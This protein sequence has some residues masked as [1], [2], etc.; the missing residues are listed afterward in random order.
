M[1][2]SFRCSLLSVV[3]PVFL[4]GPA[5]VGCPVGDIDKNCRIDLA[6]IQEF[7]QKWL[8]EGVCTDSDCANLDGVGVVNM[9]DFA[10]LAE[11][12]SEDQSQLVI[13]EFMAVNNEAYADEQGKF[14]DWIEIYNPMDTTVDLE[15]WYLTDDADE[16]PNLTKWQF[17][18]GVLL[19]PGEFIVVFASGENRRDP[20][21]PLHTNFQLGDED[22]D[23]ALVTPDGKTIAHSYLAYPRQIGDVSYGLMQFS[24]TL[25]AGGANVSYHVPTSD[26]AG[27]DFTPVDFPDSSWPTGP[28]GLNF[29]FGGT[30][31]FS[32][33][34]CVYEEGQHLGSNV[35]TYGI[36]GGFGGAT[37]GPLLD[38]ATGD[39][40]GAA[41]ALGQSGGVTWQAS[42]TGGSD[43]AAGTDAYNTFG[44]FADMTGVIYYGSVGW[45]VDIT[46]TN[47]EPGTEYTFAASAARNEYPDRWTRYT[48]SGADTHTNASTTGVYE[49]PGSGGA[50][51][52]FNTGDNHNEGY[53][54]RWTGIRA[55]D[56]TFKVRAEADPDNPCS[57]PRKAYAFDVF[58]LK[59]GFSGTNLSGQM[60]GVN[61]SVWTRAEFYLEAGERDIF[62][63]LTLRMKYEDG[64]V[65]YLNGEKV[66]SRNDPAILAWNSSATANR[67]IEE[68]AE[69]E[70]INLT[71]YVGLLRDGKNVLAIHGLNDS[72]DDGEFLVLP[73]LVAAS[74]VGV[75]QYFT[76]P[77]PRTF[78][79]EGAQGL[80]SEVWF[81]HDRGFYDSSFDLTLSTEMSS[82]E[83]RY[84]TDGS[85]PT[86]SHGR[87][88]SGPV[89]INGTSTIRAVAVKPGYLDSDVKTHTYIFVSDVIHQ[90]PNGERP[91]SNW[92]TD[93]T[94]GQKFEYGMDTA[95]VNHGT[96]GPLLDDALTAIPTMSVVTD[97]DNLFYDSSSSSTGGIYVNAG[98]DGRAWERPT[99]LE[100]IYPPDPQG[101]GFPDLLRAADG[102]AGSQWQLPRNMQ[103]GFQIDCGIRIRGGY[104]RSGGNPKHAF[105]FFFR[106]EYGDGKLNYPLFGT[107]GA[108]RFD[109]VDLR[110][111]QNYSW[112]FANDGSNAMC[113]DVWARD[114]QGL[115]GEPYT[116][117]RYYHLYI[118][119][120]YWG[121]FQTQ[122]RS[123]AAYAE[124]YFGGDRDDYDTVK[125]VGDG[126]YAIEATD[127]TLD[128]W[129]D[130][131]DL[132]NLGFEN[133][134]IYNQAQGLY[135]DG[136]RNPDYPVLLDI[137][138]LIDYMIQVFYDGDRDAPISWFLSENK[139]NNWYGIRSRVGDRGFRY[140]VHD[141]EHTLSRGLPSRV[142]PFPAGDQF[143]YS[144]PQWIHQELMAHPDYRLRFAD[145]VQKRLFG[146]GL[147][148][149]TNA[150]ERFR[151]R[152]GQIDMAIIAE[153]A[154]WGSS[155]LTKSTWQSA[156]NNEINNFFPNRT[157]AIISQLKTTR[158]RDD[159]LAPLYPSIDAPSFSHSGGEVARNYPLSMSASGTIYYTLDGSDPRLD[160]SQSLSSSEVTLIVEDAAKRILIP[161]EPVAEPP[162]SILYEYW[163]GIAGGSVANLTIQP[164][165]PDNPDG[166]DYLT[167]F[168]APSNWADTYGARIVGY[169]HPPASGDYTFWIATNDF[170]ELWLST[171]RKSVV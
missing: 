81:S 10:K 147:L 37:S 158:L 28:T 126:D 32:F 151:Q 87:V 2:K 20:D 90:S 105:R 66:A 163:T 76:T 137:D 91:D 9:S 113:R 74:A 65:A 154:R 142:G 73:E 130:L 7:A 14:P 164:D 71:E 78:N 121:L 101:D 141:A 13:S 100:L 109:K 60:E 117:S 114:S 43:C 49:I 68:A 131:W 47:L 4:F 92:P 110:T 53:V 45:W 82:V 144:N 35:T 50:S 63:K 52:R 160:V 170:G 11:H 46:F 88:Y 146:S 67:P 79:V 59:G 168:E 149:P 39:P 8:E 1:H 111:A 25:V 104:S 102:G 48:I 135:P 84:T 22:E 42:G 167:T 123:E 27:T 108:D 119:G 156:I 116:R 129:R 169:V 64:F 40:T 38:Q 75:P 136:T 80:V 21:N 3:L 62:E 112:S 69:F 44:G 23:V 118:N 85:R 150:I 29:G 26:D 124:T 18:A 61:A 89:R 134:T 162:G 122:E 128:A 94:R 139:P 140:F 133:H 155:S 99:S 153:S 103:G 93:G 166:G 33:N 96:W 31:R 152:A 86:I 70:T 5:A 161:A 15:G 145:H 51:V 171:D 138:N 97:L 95:I 132:A 16:D 30:E 57:D 165:Y 143:Q 58:M 54:A 19:N 77:T 120:H 148:T 56:G 127:G 115:T 12:W 36:G 98:G 159:S 157:T 83:I 17:P 6:D 125:A 72:K 34:D 41:V 106:D 24:R 55:S 107:E